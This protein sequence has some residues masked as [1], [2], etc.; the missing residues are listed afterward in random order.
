MTFSTAHSLLVRALE[1]I[2]ASDRESHLEVL[3]V[4]LSVCSWAMRDD[5]WADLFESLVTLPFED[6]QIVRVEAE[7]VGRPAMAPPEVLAEVD[8]AVKELT[9]MTD[10]VQIERVARS[11]AYVDRVADCRSALWRVVEDGREGGAVAT[12]INSLAHLCVDDYFLGRWD[13]VGELAEE[14]LRLCS[15]HGYQLMRWQFRFGQALVA[16]ARGRS[17]D[18]DAISAEMLEWASPREVGRV[19]GFANHIRALAAVRPG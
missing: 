17:N 9:H 4:L 14:G 11:C 13:E 19:Q 6:Q 15:K 10:L 1:T 12:A 8:V 18:V 16:A 2:P 3:L 5:M 7:L